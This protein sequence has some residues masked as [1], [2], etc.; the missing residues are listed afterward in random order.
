[1]G[2]KY[3]IKLKGTNCYLR[4]TGGKAINFT[5]D[6]KKAKVFEED[7]K[8][9][10]LIDK[11]NAREYK[12]RKEGS[13]VDHIN[14]TMDRPTWMEMYNDHLDQIKVISDS[15]RA[16]HQYDFS[17]ADKFAVKMK[18]FQISDE[19]PNFNCQ[20]YGEDFERESLS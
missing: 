3:M 18:S 10:D 2:K 12:V 7:Y 6:I 8:K 13:K 14:L 1:M 19:F 20:Y 9:L 15:R 5:T 4:N 17:L 16:I 11:L